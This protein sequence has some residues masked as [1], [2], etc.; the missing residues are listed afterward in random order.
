MA[1]VKRAKPSEKQNICKSVVTLLKKRYK[2]GAPNTKS[3]VLE[4]MLQA[5]CLEDSSMEQADAAYERLGTD[6]F[7]LNEVRVSGISELEAV[8]EG[9]VDPEWKAFRVRSLLNEIFERYYAFDFEV[10]RRRTLEQAQKELDKFKNLSPFVK[11]Y[12]LHVVNG[13]HVVPIDKRMLQVAIWLG[14][15]DPGSTVESGAEQLK[16]AIRKADAT[17]FCHYLRHLA[18]DPKVEAI[19]DL[20]QTPPPETGFDAF[21]APKRLAQAIEEQETHA[22][23]KKSARKGEVKKGVARRSKSTGRGSAEGRTSAARRKK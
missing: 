3:P 7:D 23:K 17:S 21:S 20:E 4:T 19:F 5:V 11:L 6:F 18:T 1:A 10:L 15:V 2:S 12:T 9:M 16:A 13:A 8:F 22:R 14:V